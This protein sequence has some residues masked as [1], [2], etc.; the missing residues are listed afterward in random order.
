MEESLFPIYNSSRIGSSL[1]YGKA[2]VW[3]QILQWPMVSAVPSAPAQTPTPQ[4]TRDGRHSTGTLQWDTN[5]AHSL[6]LPRS[7]GPERSQWVESSKV[8]K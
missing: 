8:T 4:E 2:R 6:H 7:S 1:Y 3:E 5:G